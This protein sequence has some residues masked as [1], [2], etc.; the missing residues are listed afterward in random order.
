MIQFS[1][2]LLKGG[3]LLADTRR[4]IEVWED[5]ASTGDNLDRITDGNL[6][7]KNSRTRTADVLKYVLGPRF[8]APGRHVIPALRLL[9]R[10]PDAFREACYYEASRD[11]QLL[12]AFSEGPVFDW[13]KSGRPTVN[14]D[15]TSRWLATFLAKHQTAWTESV[16]TK[17]ARGL[18]AALR[19]F[20]VF[21]GANLK[22]FAVPRLSTA[23]F[24]YVAFRQH[25]QGV[26]SRG[27]VHGNVW[28][29]WLLE[30]S[31]VIELFTHAERLGVLSYSQAGSLVRV[32]WKI[33]SLE[34]VGRAAA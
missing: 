31:R 26:S 11:D 34:E 7:A 4:L 14:L 30:E 9:I 8:V 6:L 20:G 22:R 10:T 33:K 25:E 2:K 13:Y 18:L 15:E 28:R 27:L 3:A 19:D 32:D 1:S 16:Q 12:A 29:R 17:V 23:G 24:S 5:D 21:D